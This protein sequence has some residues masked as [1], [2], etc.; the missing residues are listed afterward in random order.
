[1]RF[2]VEKG[3]G[4]PL[5]KAN[6]LLKD[7]I[8]MQE[9]EFWEDRLEFLNQDYVVAFRKFKGKIRYSIFCRLGHKNSAFK[10]SKK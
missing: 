6:A 8:D 1:M 3:E 7:I 9:L 2:V 4:I 5:T 10:V